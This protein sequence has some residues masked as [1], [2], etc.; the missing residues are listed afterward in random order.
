MH[1]IL[2]YIHILWEFILFFY[3]L[4]ISVS[5]FSAT[6]RIPELLI[7]KKRRTQETSPPVSGASVCFCPLLCRYQLWLCCI[8]HSFVF[9]C[10]AMTRPYH[11]PHL[12]SSQ[13]V[14]L[15]DR[16]PSCKTRICIDDGIQLVRDNDDV[17]VSHKVSRV[18]LIF[19]PPGAYIC[20][21]RVFNCRH[22]LTMNL[23]C[24]Q[25]VC[26]N[27]IRLNQGIFSSRCPYT[28]SA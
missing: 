2:F 23:Y 5:L 22:S 15:S 11:P 9:A 3:L 24:Q 13:C 27:Y 18:L 1:F 20:K 17:F 21:K 8:F 12:K 26:P 28:C 25:P 14:P 6:I 16:F 7:Q 4:F 19:L 10:S